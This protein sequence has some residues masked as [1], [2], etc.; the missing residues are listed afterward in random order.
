HLACR[1]HAA[2]VQTR[3]VLPE[4]GRWIGVG[5]AALGAAAVADAVGQRLATAL[6]SA[7]APF[8]AGAGALGTVVILARVVVGAARR[9]A[10]RGWPGG[11]ARFSRGAPSRPRGRGGGWPR[12]RRT[13]RPAPGAGG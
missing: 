7:A 6:P 9:R 11:A 1:C 5:V 10:G 2:A 8:L 12:A 3:V 4:L 13:P